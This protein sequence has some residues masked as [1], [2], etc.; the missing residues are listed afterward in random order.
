MKIFR[1][2]KHDLPISLSPLADD[3]VLICAIK[4]NFMETLSSDD[5]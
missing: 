2:I 5:N 4:T 3:I 1:I